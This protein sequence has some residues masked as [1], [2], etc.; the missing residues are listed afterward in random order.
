[1]DSLREATSTWLAKL[2]KEDRIALFVFTDKPRLR[3]PL[4]TNKK[5]VAAAISEI[6]AGGKTNIHEALSQAAQYL[7]KEAPQERGSIILASDDLSASLGAHP[8][9]EDVLRSIQEANATLYNLKIAN[10]L[11]SIPPTS[12][13]AEKSDVV[14]VPKMVAAT[15]G[16]VAEVRNPQRLSEAFGMIVTVLKTRYTLGFYPKNA[17]GDTS[18]HKLDLRLAPSFG[19]K[20]KDYKILSKDGYYA[21]PPH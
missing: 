2:K 17:P 1:M 8:S 10:P 9:A 19:E 7:K 6:S 5:L 21:S 20:G 3:V 16:V 15:G 13:L 18:Y 4:T 14:Q 11:V 12:A